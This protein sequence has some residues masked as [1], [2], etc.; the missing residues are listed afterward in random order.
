MAKPVC[1]TK[2]T[3]IEDGVRR[4]KWGIYSDANYVVSRW[5]W[6][7]SVS[8]VEHEILTTEFPDISIRPTDT[9]SLITSYGGLSGRRRGAA[10]E[11]I[12]IVTRRT[13]ICLILL[14]VDHAKASL[15]GTPSLIS[16]GIDQFIQCVMP[17]VEMTM[18]R[19]ELVKTVVIVKM[20]VRIAQGQV[21]CADVGRRNRKS[22]QRVLARRDAAFFDAAKGGRQLLVSDNPILQEPLLIDD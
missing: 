17:K 15:G 14:H 2:P 16:C 10:R 6:E 19:S 21:G 22:Q 9:D 5:Y 8:S 18:T 3:G 11:I 7:L 20:N 1:I 12:P 13:R 4:H